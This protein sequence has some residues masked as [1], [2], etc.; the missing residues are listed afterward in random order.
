MHNA[1]NEREDDGPYSYENDLKAPLG[2]TKVGDTALTLNSKE[3]INETLANNFCIPFEF[4]QYTQPNY[5]FGL[6]EN[7]RV[8]V[9]LN[10]A[11][12][13][14]LANAATKYTI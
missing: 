7:L 14:V 4:S 13:I 11:D 9:V 5:P 12:Y 8:K 3:T 2:A 6:K 10:S 1:K